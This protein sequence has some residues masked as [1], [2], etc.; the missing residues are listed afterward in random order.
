MAPS[1]LALALLVAAVGSAAAAGTFEVIQATTYTQLKPVAGQWDIT[2]K[3]TKTADKAAFE[4]QLCTEDTVKAACNQP[5]LSADAKDKLQVTA[6]LK[7]A[8]LRTIDNLPPTRIVVK[9]CYTKPS[10]TD[11]PWRKSNDVI[12]K[13]KSCPFIIKSAELNATSFT[14]DW[15]IPKNMTKAAWYA[16]VLVQCT[17]GTLT[18]FCQADNTK[19][20]TYWGTT[21]INSTPPGMVVATAV[22]SAIGPL[23]L[24]GYFV[25]DF[26]ARRKL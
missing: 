26:F 23:F 5:L 4:P 13:D 2:V 14:F 25:K 24:G 6:A 12:D 21:I 20:A 7:A 17:N 3:A 19:N 16:S 18:S 10:S 9:A 1:A 22:C 8:P 11:R 15:P